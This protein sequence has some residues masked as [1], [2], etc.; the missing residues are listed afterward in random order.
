M[1]TSHCCSARRGRDLD[2]ELERTEGQRSGSALPWS[3]TAKGN[4]DMGQ[5]PT[6][7]EAVKKGIYHEKT[8]RVCVLQ[9]PSPSESPQRSA[10]V[11]SYTF[12]GHLRLCYLTGSYQICTTTCKPLPTLQDSNVPPGRASLAPLLGESPSAGLPCTAHCSSLTSTTA[13]AMAG[14]HP[15]CLRKTTPEGQALLTPVGSKSNNGKLS[16]FSDS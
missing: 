11:N 3:S 2:C 16:L 13:P 10:N 7:V 5:Q 1:R 14:T 9:V 12:P 15:I 4:K 6:W 8:C